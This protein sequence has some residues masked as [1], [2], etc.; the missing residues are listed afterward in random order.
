MNSNKCET[1]DYIT[2]C[3]PKFRFEN[4]VAFKTA[5][6]LFLS[7]KITEKEYDDINDGLVCGKLAIRAIEQLLSLG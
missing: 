7:D 5:Q 6:S 2:G 3:L 4:E 1:I